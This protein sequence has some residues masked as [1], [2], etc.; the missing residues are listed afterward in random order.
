MSMWIVLASV[1][2]ALAH[3]EWVLPKWS[4]LTYRRSSA[5]FL[6]INPVT[7]QN[8]PLSHAI[9]QQEWGIMNVKVHRYILQRG[10]WAYIAVGSPVNI[11]FSCYI[12][13]NES[14]QDQLRVPWQLFIL[15]LKISHVSAF[16]FACLPPSMHNNICSDLLTKRQKL[17]KKYRF[18]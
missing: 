1:I 13:L 2:I 7:S 10:I 3:I 17:T 16:K 8:R 18:N 5:S 4:L 14:S 15:N 12:T 11:V 6:E 9:A